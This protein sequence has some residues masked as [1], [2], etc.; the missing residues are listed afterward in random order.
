M[1]SR[2]GPGSPWESTPIGVED[3]GA[4]LGSLNGSVWLGVAGKDCNDDLSSSWAS[5]IPPLDGTA[6][7]TRFPLPDV[8]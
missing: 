7:S 3:E 2:A 5:L 8:L 6:A 4:D 1:A